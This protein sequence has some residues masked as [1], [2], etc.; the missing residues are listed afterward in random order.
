VTDGWHLRIFGRVHGVFFRGSMCD[1][2]ASLGARGW[3]NRGDGSVEAVITGERAAVDALRA[4]ARSGPPG[5]W[6]ERVDERA[7]TAAELALAGDGF[8]QLG[9]EF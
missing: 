2:A 9:T 6:V 1:A 8:R 4:W 3:R 5:A 7:A